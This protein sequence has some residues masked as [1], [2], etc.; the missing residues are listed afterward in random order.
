MPLKDAEKYKHMYKHLKVEG[1][2]GM[3][4]GVTGK[5][6]ML[7]FVDDSRDPRRFMQNLGPGFHE[8]LHALMQQ[9]IGTEHVTYLTYGNSPDA[10]NMQGKKGPAATVVVHDTWYGTKTK[11]K[12]WF[13]QSMMWLPVKMPYIPVW[14]AKEVYKISPDIN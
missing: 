6:Q 1:S 4:W 14:Y 3:A 11:V 8:T 13:F 7:W 5:N 9:E 10:P 12:L 2:G